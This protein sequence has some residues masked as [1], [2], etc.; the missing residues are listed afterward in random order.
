MFGIVVAGWVIRER[1]RLGCSSSEQTVMEEFPHYGNQ[2]FEPFSGEVECIVRY[3]TNA[4]RDE[5]LTHYEERLREN[6]WE[7][8]W[9]FGLFTAA[10]PKTKDKTGGERLSDLPAGW[11]GGI[12]ACR[13]GYRYL[14]EYWPPPEPEG[15]QKNADERFSSGGYPVSGDKAVV[16]VGV[17]DDQG[18]PCS[19]VR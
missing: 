18:A 6:G 9:A 12:A 15:K 14:V 8:M 3:T 5:V 1:T 17:S 13:G 4:S 16:D 19:R 10:D 11:A 2:R 7:A